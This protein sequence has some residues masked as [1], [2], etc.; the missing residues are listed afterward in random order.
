MPI[1]SCLFVSFVSS[2][3]NRRYPRFPSLVDFG[4]GEERAGGAGGGRVAELGLDLRGRHVPA[5]QDGDEAVGGYGLAI[6][7]GRQCWKQARLPLCPV[8]RSSKS[9]PL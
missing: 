3:F 1:S 6:A 5:L 7:P 4:E 2:W 8:R 9:P